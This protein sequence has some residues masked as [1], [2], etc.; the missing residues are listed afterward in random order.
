MNLTAKRSWG[1]CSKRL[2]MQEGLVVG[3]LRVSPLDA[4][5][6]LELFSSQFQFIFSNSRDAPFGAS[7][8]IQLNDLYRLLTLLG[9]F[10]F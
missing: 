5:V 2:E 6:R 4:L 10:V 1:R 9:V 3:G 7:Q 8:H